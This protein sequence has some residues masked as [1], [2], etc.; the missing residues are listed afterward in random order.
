L[1]PPRYVAAG[2]LSFGYR[3]SNLERVDLTPEVLLYAYAQGVFPMAHPEEDGAIYWYAPEPRGI[4]PLDSFHVPKNLARLVRR[5]TFE[6]TADRD[7][8]AVMQACAE[9]QS[10]REQSWISDELI[11]LYTA[12][13]RRGHAHSL[14]IWRDGKLAGGLYGVSLGA[15]FFGESMFSRETDAS[16]VALVHLVERLRRGGFTLLDIQFITEHLRQFGAI[17]IPRD[18]YERR[19]DEAKQL[20]ADWNAIARDA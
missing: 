6:V 1:G 11:G 5:S 9:P 10:G 16:K 15:A 20:K 13:H 17:E 19:L 3:Q 7:F 18:E 14:E 12:L 2:V 4:L 8:E